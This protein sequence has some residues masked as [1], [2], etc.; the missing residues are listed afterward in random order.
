MSNFN[1]KYNTNGECIGDCNDCIHH[2]S[3]RSCCCD[4]LELCAKCECYG[5][6]KEGVED[7]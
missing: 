4:T 5:I 2:D 7:E 3:C 1:C 6:I